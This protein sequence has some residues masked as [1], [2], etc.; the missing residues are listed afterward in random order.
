MTG[1]TCMQDRFVE[2]LSHGMKQRVG[3]ARTLL[4]D[5]AVLILDEPANGLDPPGPD[6]D[7]ADSCCGWPERG[8]TLIVT[9]HI[10]PEL[11]RICDLVA[12]IT[13]GQAAGVR[14]A[15]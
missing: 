5:P 15:R 11:A 1:A 7:A 14:H 6:R 2:S 12:I 8:K 4:H 9:S 10:L 3:I 13:H